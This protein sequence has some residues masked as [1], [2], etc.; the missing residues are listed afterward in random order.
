MPATP[1]TAPYLY[2]GLVAIFS[3]V[4]LFV[5]SMVMR[6]RTLRADLQR[7]ERYA[8]DKYEK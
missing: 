1:D 4:S 5:A 8:K 7:V 3:I 6:Y 2:L